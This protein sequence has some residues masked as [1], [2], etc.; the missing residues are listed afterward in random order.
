MPET[1]RE[2][3]LAA[4]PHGRPTPDCFDL[5][6]VPVPEPAEGEA[7]VRNTYLSVDPYM[8]GRMRDVKSY[9]PPF[10][11]GEA[12]DGGA[13][14]Q[15][16]ASRNPD[17]PEGR[18]VQSMQG[19]REHYVTDGSALL[20]VA[21]PEVAPVSA[22]LGVLGMPGFT[23]WVGLTQIGRPKEGETVF[24][25]AAAGAV[26]STVGQLAKQRGCRAVGSAGSAEKVEWLTGELGFDAAFDY[27]DADLH[28]ELREHCPDGIDVYFDNV[29]GEQ[30]EAALGRMNVFGRIPVCGAIATYNEEELLPGPLGFLAVIPKRLTI[31]GFIVTDHYDRYREFLEEVSPLVASGAITYRETVVEG[32]ENMPDAFLGLLDGHNTGKMLVRVGPEPDTTEA[33]GPPGP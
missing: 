32:I 23:A 5:A 33:T 12:M 8:R 24:V 31:R 14:G 7:L 2:I 10:Q 25:S 22:S 16:V 17:L 9:V 11:V 27:H 1:S 15:V 18:W 30:L 3:R 19:W 26:G 13:V 21:D 29:G 6:E 20:P 28:A 4:R